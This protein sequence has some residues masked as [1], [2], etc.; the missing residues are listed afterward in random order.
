MPKSPD[1]EKL[2][3]SSGKRSAQAD[4]AA[5]QAEIAQLEA[6]AVIQAAE[7]KRQKEHELKK[8]L[9]QTHKDWQQV[10]K[11]VKEQAEA[12]RIA[13]EAEAQRQLD[14]INATR[15]AFRTEVYE[16]KCE[17]QKQ[18]AIQKVQE[19]AEKEKILE[20]IKQEAPYAEKIAQIEA[21]PNRT[22]QATVAFKANVEAAQE[23]LG[24]HETGLFP[25]HGYDTDKL[26][27]DA[28][29]KLGLALRDAGLASTEY[30]KKAMSTIALRNGGS[31]R[32]VAQPAT[33]LW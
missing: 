29:F 30:A 31:Y 23:G 3:P 28:R 16:Q 20:A 26:F 4:V 32:H 6:E 25:S 7:R 15:V 24:I 18:K 5:H 1:S 2:T 17:L 22:R 13:A 11:L 19:E 10:E 8:K 9:L 12:E 27:K 14:A 33:Q 21:D